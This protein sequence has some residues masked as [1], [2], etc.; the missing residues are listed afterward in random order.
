M[1]SAPDVFFIALPYLD[2]QDE[3]NDPKLIFDGIDVTGA[4]PNERHG[5]PSGAVRRQMENCEEY[6]GGI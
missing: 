5:P 1:T 6:S 3:L 2:S 4:N